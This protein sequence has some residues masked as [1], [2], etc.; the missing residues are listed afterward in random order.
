MPITSLLSRQLFRALEGA[1]FP[2]ERERLVWVARE[3]DAEREVLT[4]LHRLPPSRYASAA[5]VAQ[6]LGALEAE[7]AVEP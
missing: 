4:H 7:V 5:Q 1:V 3:N 2:L 6:A